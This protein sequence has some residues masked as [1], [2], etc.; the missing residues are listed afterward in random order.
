MASEVMDLYLYVR[1]PVHVGG[2]QEKHLSG[3]I[4][5][6]AQDDQIHILDHNKL[7]KI[8]GQ[9]QFINALAQGPEGV[10]SLIRNRRIPIV[11]IR[12]NSFQITG[13]ANDYKAIVKDGFFGRPFIPGSSVKGAIRSILFN[14][15]FQLSGESVQAVTSHTKVARGREKPI[16]PDEYLM[17]DFENS[18]M[19]FVHCSDVS[20]QEFRLFNTKVFNLFKVSGQWEGGWKH[21]LENNTSASFAPEGFTTAYESIPMGAIGTFRLSFDKQLFVRY[22]SREGP[23]RA[24]LTTFVTKLLKGKEFMGML[25]ESIANYTNTYLSREEEFFNSFS[26]SETSGILSQIKRLH[27]ENTIKTPLFRLASGSGFHSMTGD[28]RFK[29][30]LETIDKIDRKNKARN[31]QHGLHYKSR[32]LAFD[33]DEQGNYHFYPMGFV[34]LITPE[35]Y[36]QN[37]KPEIEAEKAAAAEQRRRMAEAERQRLEEEKRIAE[38]ARKPKMRSLREVKKEGLLDGEV[39]GQKGKLVQVRPFV[40]GWESRTL[41]VRYAAGFPKGT[42]VEVKARMQGKQLTLLPPPKEKNKKP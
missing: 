9:E 10:A 38:E 27:Q 15:L 23:R 29:G 33:S 7:M 42:I 31:Y 17:G 12:K 11:S 30:H 26:V 37:L 5:Y 1:T 20:F 2:A 25:F 14:M 6:I 24:P 40:E 4:D 41:E 16:K 32:R 21:Q 13:I 35:Y 18:L 22:G 39:V 19:R 36:E 8:A 28:W 34:Q 3:G